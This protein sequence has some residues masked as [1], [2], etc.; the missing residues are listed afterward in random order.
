VGA[1]R[2]LFRTTRGQLAIDRRSVAHAVEP[3]RH[4]RLLARDC[5]DFFLGGSA[6]GELPGSGL[7][8]EVRLTFVAARR[9]RSGSDKAKAH[10]AYLPS[11]HADFSNEYAILGQA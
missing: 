4:A 7:L 1:A 8:D 11:R 10:A 5:A 3:R 9:P 6:L 2:D